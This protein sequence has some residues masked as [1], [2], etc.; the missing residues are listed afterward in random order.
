MPGLR[1]QGA[2]HEN[3]TSLVRIARAS[4]FYTKPICSWFIANPG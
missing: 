1:G 3:E 4:R 2:F